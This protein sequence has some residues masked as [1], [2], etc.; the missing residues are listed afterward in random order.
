M[1]VFGVAQILRSKLPNNTFDFRGFANE[2]DMV[3][4]LQSLP[5]NEV[6]T[7][8]RTGAGE[9]PDKRC[10]KREGVWFRGIWLGI[11]YVVGWGW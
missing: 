3:Q 4:E 8:F 1:T 7:C 2:L 9:T 11:G 10:G 6:T 5:E